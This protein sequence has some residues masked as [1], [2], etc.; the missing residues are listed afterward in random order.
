MRYSYYQILGDQIIARC[1][2]TNGVKSQ[3][4]LPNENGGYIGTTAPILSILFWHITYN[5]LYEEYGV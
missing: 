1:S 2:L 5:L 3:W 4:H